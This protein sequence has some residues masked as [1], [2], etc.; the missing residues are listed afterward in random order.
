M[1]KQGI[2]N[3]KQANHLVLNDSQWE[4]FMGLIAA[5]LTNP[6]TNLK[7]AIL[8]FKKRKLQKDI[9]V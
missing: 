9:L 3:L 1:A 6:N 4:E 5:P 8:I 2:E 7:Q